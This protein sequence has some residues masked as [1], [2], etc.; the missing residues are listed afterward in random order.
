MNG[1]VGSNHGRHQQYSIRAVELGLMER[2]LHPPHAGLDLF[3]VG[4]RQRVAPMSLVH[5]G[6]DSQARLIR[7]LFD[8]DG[9][10]VGVD[11]ANL[12]FVK[13]DVDG[14]LEL[15]QMGQLF[16]EHRDQDRFLD[17]PPGRGGAQ[18]A[19]ECRRREC[20]ARAEKL[21]P[22]LHEFVSDQAMRISQNRS[23]GYRLP[24]YS[25]PWM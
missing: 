5:H 8:L 13:S 4:A 14:Q 11:G 16:R 23:L 24:E 7:G 1:R 19:V 18:S 20:G 25:V 10:V 9:F 3:R 22:G 15:I 21:T 17:L 2:Q 12:H 6:M